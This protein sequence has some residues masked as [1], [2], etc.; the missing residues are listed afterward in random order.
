M[1]A[2]GVLRYGQVVG[3]LDVARGAGWSASGSSPRSLR[4]RC[5]ARDE[6]APVRLRPWLR[7][8]TEQP[9]ARPSGAASSR[10]C[11][12]LSSSTSSSSRGRALVSRRT[13]ASAG[14]CFPSCTPCARSGLLVGGEEPA[15][16]ARGI[17]ARLEERQRQ[18]DEAGVQLGLRAVGCAATAAGT[19]SRV[20]PAS[21]AP[22]LRTEPC[23]QDQGG[24]EGRSLFTDTPP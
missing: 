4:A 9:L 13:P 24:H 16:L 2:E 1:R 11:W 23:Q 15:V 21:A 20:S 19:G 22:W 5:K 8:L 7:Q 6:R 3:A 17:S 18:L 10:L 12:R 14:T